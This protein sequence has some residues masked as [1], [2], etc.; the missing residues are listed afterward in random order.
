MALKND[1]LLLVKFPRG[2]CTLR[3]LYHGIGENSKAEQIDEKKFN[4]WLLVY[5]KKQ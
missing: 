4:S 5:H 3:F 2:V 1:G